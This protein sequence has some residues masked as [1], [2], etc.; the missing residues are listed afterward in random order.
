MERRQGPLVGADPRRARRRGDVRPAREAALPP[1]RVVRPLA[2]RPHPRELPLRAA[3]GRRAGAVR[4]AR[5]PVVTG[6]GAA[7]VVVVGAGVMVG[8]L[9]VGA[10]SGVSTLPSDV[11]TSNDCEASVRLPVG[12]VALTCIV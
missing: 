12:V 7:V 9:G 10:I 2:P 5:Q 4:G 1:R 8:A 3:R 6:A 11:N